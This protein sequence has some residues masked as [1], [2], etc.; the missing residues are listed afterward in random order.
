MS[1]N[2][3]MSARTHLMFFSLRKDETQKIVLHTFSQNPLFSPFPHTIYIHICNVIF[4]N[5]HVHL[6]ICLSRKNG[7]CSWM[8]T[9][10]A[11][12]EK[13]GVRVWECVRQREREI[14]SGNRENGSYI[15]CF[16]SCLI[17]IILC[18]HKFS[19]IGINVIFIYI[20]YTPI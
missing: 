8:H 3:L 16:F 20:L 6:L 19:F 9:V 5:T 13:T 7:K 4:I 17:Q 14:L 11:E 1:D 15:S 2:W 18:T 10:C 12:K